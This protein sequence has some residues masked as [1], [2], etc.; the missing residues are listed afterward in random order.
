MAYFM[1]SSGVVSSGGVVR[2]DLT[3]AHDEDT[4]AQRQDLSHLGRHHDDGLPFP[5]DSLMID[6]LRLR[7]D[8]DSAGRLVQ[9]QESR[10]PSAAVLAII[11]LL[12]V[13]ALRCFTFRLR[14]GG[15]DREALNLLVA[16]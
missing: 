4:V 1:T 10:D 3:L 7:P 15:L 11:D 13:A 2:G 9:D 8:V 5:R 12:L 6:N 14:S 16:A